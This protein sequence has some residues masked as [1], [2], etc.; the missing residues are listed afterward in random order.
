MA[1]Y[2]YQMGMSNNAVEA[3]ERGLKTA[4]KIGYGLTKKLIEKYCDYAEWHHTGSTFYN[5]TKFYDQEYVLAVFGIQETND[6]KFDDYRDE[7]AVSDFND[8]KNSKKNKKTEEEEVKVYGEYAVWCGS[9][10]HPKLDYW[11]D[12]KGILKDNWII[13]KDGSK[14]KADGNWIKFDV[15]K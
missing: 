4:S 7:D 5:S 11:Q 8:Y 1:G 14:K 10:K 2:N 12:F 13:L 6:F 3:H 9:R 15:I